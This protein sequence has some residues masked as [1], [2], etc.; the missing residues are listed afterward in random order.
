MKVVHLLSDNRLQPGVSDV[1]TSPHSTLYSETTA[2][3][4]AMRTNVAI[5]SAHARWRCIFCTGSCSVFLG[6]VLQFLLSRCNMVSHPV[7]S[8]KDH[9]RNK[10]SISQWSCLIISNGSQR[11]R[12]MTQL[13]LN[14]HL[15]AEQVRFKD[16]MGRRYNCSRDGKNE[17]FCS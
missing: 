12:F 5:L 2:T 4:L 9:R 10:Q 6:R 14:S 16:N 8:L 17:I 1:T 3:T 7:P 15:P 13:L 11:T